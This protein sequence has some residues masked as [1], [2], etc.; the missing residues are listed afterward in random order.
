MPRLIEYTEKK[1]KLI[2]ENDG[3][4]SPA[5]NSAVYD[6]YK[7]IM[8]RDEKEL[9]AEV[10]EKSKDK[11][12]STALIFAAGYGFPLVA[13]DKLCNAGSNINELDAY[14]DSA[15]KWAVLHG[16]CDIVDYFLRRKGIDLSTFSGKNGILDLLASREKYECGGESD[17][18][19]NSC[20]T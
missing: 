11:Y 14:G 18:A 17:D 8:T 6:L 12:G 2:D 16:Y 15:F 7:A 10:N 19:P 4:T 13:I 5:S 1:R 9:L 20:Q 3:Y